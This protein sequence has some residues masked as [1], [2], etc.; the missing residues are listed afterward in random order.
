M[1]GILPP[2]Q[3]KLLNYPIHSVGSDLVAASGS[4]RVYR[5]RLWSI[6]LY[7]LQILYRVGTS[8]TLHWTILRWWMV[9]GLSES[10]FSRLCPGQA[11][12]TRTIV[13]VLWRE[14]R[15]DSEDLVL[16]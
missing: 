7:R 1:D 4:P 14:L 9:R 15:E 13:H 16:N 8:A 5:M 2:P 12:A 3:R 11:G 6:L 10:R